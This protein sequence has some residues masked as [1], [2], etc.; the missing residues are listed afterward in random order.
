MSGTHKYPTISFQYLSEREG[1]N[2]SKDF[3]KWHEEKDYLSVPA[4]ITGCAW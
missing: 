4:F 2:R 1:R 3:H